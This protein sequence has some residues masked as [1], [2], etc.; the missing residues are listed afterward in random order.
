MVYGTMGGDGQPQTQ[1]ALFTRH[2]RYGQDLATAIAAPRWLLGRTWGTP[3]IELSLESRFDPALVAAL[4]AAGHR[5]RSVGA[6]DALMGHAGAIVRHPDGLL[7]GAAD[8]RGDGCA[9]AY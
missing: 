8:P 2:V 6:Y 7:E 1:A 4:A 3:R 5:V 9:A